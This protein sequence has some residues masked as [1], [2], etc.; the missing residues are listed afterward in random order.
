MTQE[1]LLVSPQ[2]ISDLGSEEEDDT[3]RVNM[4]EGGSES[5]SHSLK[6]GE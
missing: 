4:D 6:K 2:I 3:E 1:S 5:T